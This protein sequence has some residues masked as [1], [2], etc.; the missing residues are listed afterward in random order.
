MV[1]RPVDF[2]IRMS[3]PHWLQLYSRL[4][5]CN[6]SANDREPSQ[7]SNQRNSDGIQRFLQIAGAIVSWYHVILSWRTIASF[8]H[9]NFTNDS[10]L[11]AK[12]N[13]IFIATKAKKIWQHRTKKSQIAT[14]E[15]VSRPE[16][17]FNGRK[18]LLFWSTNGKDTSRST[19]H[20]GSMDNSLS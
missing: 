3:S 16:P 4:S 7:R 20:T 1:L 10:G 2:E 14:I 19:Y 18:F 9:T 17:S 11:L 8:P 13:I 6:C 15:S 5:R 12:Q